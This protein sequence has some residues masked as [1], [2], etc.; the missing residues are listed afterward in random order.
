MICGNFNDKLNYIHV[1]KPA[2]ELDLVQCH[3]FLTSD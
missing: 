2:K 1:N 3:L